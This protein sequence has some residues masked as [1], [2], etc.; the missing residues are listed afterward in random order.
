MKKRDCSK[1]ANL[2]EIHGGITAP[3]GFEAAGVYCGIKKMH[4]DLALI[5]SRAPAVACG[6]FTTNKVKAAPIRVSLR[7]LRN[8]QAQAIVVNSGNA[9]TCTGG[10]G[11][12]DAEEMAAIAARQLG[13]S[14]DEVLVAS[15]GVI[16]ESLPLS[17][18][19]EGIRK[20]SQ[21][22][23]PQGGSEAARAILTTDTTSKEISVETDIA[24]RGKKK[25]RI[26]GM[27]K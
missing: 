13:I 3:R 7:K 12:K 15:T 23:S 5:Y 8:R 14:E 27:C 11:I 2:R 25:V 17:K 22:L 4:L 18:I 1:E 24:G 9:N 10:Q 19:A 20:A 21:S 16:G 26:G 6:M